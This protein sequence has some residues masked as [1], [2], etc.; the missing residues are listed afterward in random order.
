V[1]FFSFFFFFF[2]GIQTDE[3]IRVRRDVDLTRACPCGAVLQATASA[4]GEATR[5]TEHWEGEGDARV[6]VDA[7]ATEKQALAAAEQSARDH[8]RELLDLVACPRCGA[9]PGR[10]A[11]QRRLVVATA[12]RVVAGLVFGALFGGALSLDRAARAA[13]PLLTAACILGGILAAAA[14]ARLVWRRWGNA[15]R[16]VV[17]RESAYR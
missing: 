17:L 14:E 2:F 6:F 8:A 3:V 4:T 13:G 11:L 9:K 1:P 10:A 7:A 5:G 15:Q 16:R 12:P